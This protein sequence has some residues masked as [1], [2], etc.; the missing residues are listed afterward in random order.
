[1]WTRQEA[2]DAVV[3]LANTVAAK[4]WLPATSGNLSVRF[5]DNPLVFAITRSGADKTKLLASDVLFVN[6]ESRPIEATSHR[7]SAETGV[8]ARLYRKFECQ[9]I[10]HVHTVYNNVVSQIHFANG[11]VHFTD[12]ELLKA[13]DHW[14]VNA[15]ITLP[16][17]ENH[18]DLEALSEAVA[19]AATPEVP[20]VL[21]RN[22]GIYA[23]GDSPDAAIRHLEAFEFLFQYRVVM[24]QLARRGV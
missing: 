7:P 16:I 6:E 24:Q 22:H 23:W 18:H 20:G 21:V 1:M 2:A 5:Q 8:H 19:E 4:G 15:A 10:L 14:E 12:H 17:V 3:E 13:L 9:S 11:G